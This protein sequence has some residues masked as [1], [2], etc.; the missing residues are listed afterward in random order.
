[1]TPVNRM[2]MD[3]VFSVLSLLLFVGGGAIVL[4][5][6]SMGLQRFGCFQE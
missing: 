1:M 2:L 3:F 6:F 5:I 4:E